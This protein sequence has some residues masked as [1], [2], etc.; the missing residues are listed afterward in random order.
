MSRPRIT[1]A[2]GATTRP[3]G[4]GTQCLRCKL[5]APAAATI[6]AGPAAV[7]AQRDMATLLKVTA[8]E[9]DTL[10]SQLQLIERLEGQRVDTAPSWMVPKQKA[11]GHRATLNLLLT[12]AHLDEVVDPDQIEGLNC[13][14]RAI[15]EIRLETFFTGAVK[16]ARHYL[17]GVQYDGVCL[18]LGG[19]IF[20]GNIHEELSRTNEATLFNSLL[21][22]LDPM[23]AG[24]ELLAKEFGRVHVAGTPGNHGRM[25]RKPIAKDR[26]SDNLDWLFYRLLAK[27]LQADER[28]TWEIPTGADTRVQVYDVKYLL[29]HGDQFRGGSGIAGALSPLML[30]HARKSTRQQTVGHPYDYMVIGHWHQSLFVKRI[31][32]GGAMKGYDEYAYI[33]NFDFEVPKQPLWI[34][35]PERGITFKAD[36]EVMD[37]KREKW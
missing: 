18:M 34:T 16:L 5:A 2:C 31:I 13:Y 4:G 20:S 7:K 37:R 22:W 27:S 12:D 10:K 15:G 21:Y 28:F 24:L 8:A 25:T 14:N 33:G 30:G 17:G 3:R 9:R 1:C 19:D 29:T 26:A 35:T 11:K 32:C 23:K 6:M 36:I